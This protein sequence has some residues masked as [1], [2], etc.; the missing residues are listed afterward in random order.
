V[1]T[2]MMGDVDV[3]NDEDG[4]GDDVTDVPIASA[5]P[6]AAEI[7]FVSLRQPPDGR[8]LR[9]FMAVGGP[10]AYLEALRCASDTADGMCEILLALLLTAVYHFR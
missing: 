4:D 8:T 1:T 10:R 6:A 3:H 7:R 5:A 2:L 9:I